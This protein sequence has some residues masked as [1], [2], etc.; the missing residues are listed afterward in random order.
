MT[1]GFTWVPNHR[2]LCRLLGLIVSS[3]MDWTEEGPEIAFPR[4]L[5]T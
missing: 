4:R 1:L 2:C 5:S 3:G